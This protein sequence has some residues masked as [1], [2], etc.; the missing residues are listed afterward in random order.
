MSKVGELQ[1]D[2]EHAKVVIELITGFLDECNYADNSKFKLLFDFLYSNIVDDWIRN[3][4]ID[5]YTE[6]ANQVESIDLED[7]SESNQ[8]KKRK[9]LT[10]I[11]KE[12]TR[13]D[14]TLSIQSLIASPGSNINSIEYY[15]KQINGLKSE[16]NE[17]VEKDKRKEKQLLDYELKLKVAKKDKDIKESWEKKITETFK[18]LEKILQPLEI[19]KRKLNILF[20]VFLGL[21]IVLVIFLCVIEGVAFHKLTSQLDLPSFKDYIILFIPV[22]VAGAL[23]WGF[24]YQMNRAQRQT[25]VLAKNIHHIKYVEGLLLA[26][27]TLSPSVDDGIT[28]VNTALDKMIANHLSLKDENTELDLLEEEKKDSMPVD[29]VL[30]ILKE[31]KGLTSK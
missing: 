24:I 15:E 12:A 8:K 23:L 27:N 18:K 28:R 31:A 4:V 7:P 10:A 17:T 19:E 30:K 26:V 6:L 16:L 14:Y 2:I 20:G 29:A 3:T 5:S 22:P 25:V 1:L 21:S 13:I 9:L 11:V